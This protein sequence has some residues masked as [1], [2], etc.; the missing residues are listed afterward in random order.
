M[1]EENKKQIFPFNHGFLIHS[2]FIHH[3]DYFED[4]DDEDIEDDDDEYDTW[5][6]FNLKEWAEENDEKFIDKLDSS[7]YPLFLSLDL[8][9]AKI[10]T[11]YPNIVWTIN[12]EEPF[13]N[14]GIDV[15]YGEI[16]TPNGGLVILIVSENDEVFR[17]VRI[18]VR[19]TDYPFIEVRKLAKHLNTYLF[20][21]NSLQ[22]LDVEDDGEIEKDLFQTH[23]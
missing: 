6:E 17:P 3:E 1:I 4:C 11:L 12:H 10:E 19:F 8:L 14:K 7:I 22:Y 9:K 21:F 5:K 13:E 20:H 23:N 15:I 18:D 2:E 16:Y